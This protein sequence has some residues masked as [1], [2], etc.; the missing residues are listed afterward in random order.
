[1]FGVLCSMFV[2]GCNVFIVCY[3]FVL[4]VVC[5][6]FFLLFVVSCSLCV[7][8]GLLFVVC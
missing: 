4:F 3:R 2:V 7:V 8:C 1:M 6:L 5:C